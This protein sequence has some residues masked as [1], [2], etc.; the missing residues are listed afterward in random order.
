[1]TID[2][3]V[4]CKLPR[5]LMEAKLRPL[6]GNRFQATGFPDLGPARYTLPDG[7]EMLLLES[8]QSVANRLEATCWDDAADCLIPELQ[9]LPYI[10]VSNGNGRPL[11]NSILEAH[12]INSPYILEGKDRS[13]FERLK[14]DAAGMEIGPVKLRQL[15][16][17][18]FKYDPNAILHGVFLSK[19]ELAGGRLRLSRALSG[20]IEAH[21]VKLAESGG[22][23]ND[24]VDPSGDTKKG[25][26]NVP[27]HRTEFVARQIK[28]YFN[29]DLALLRGYGL[30]DDATQLLIALSFFK[31]RR[32][33]S[34]GLRLR[35]A[36]DLT[37]DGDLT[38]TQPAGFIV[39]DE[40]SLLASCRRLIDTCAKQG[41]FA[42]P[43]ITTVQWEA[44]SKASQTTE[45][46]ESP[47]EEDQA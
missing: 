18:V 40:P 15:A 41:L 2:Y 22:V 21:D 13:M 4:L 6:Q 37:T 23:K 25:F 20:F 46:G 47:D 33:L 27:F 38:V 36:C 7:T 32:F 24:R 28:A 14:T 35:T 39:P 43:P 10:L 17:L 3:D 1:M 16:S 42:E 11:T 26:G 45:S 34:T 31:I 44:P 12:R 5:L 8:P 29:L 30:G 19:S 9:G